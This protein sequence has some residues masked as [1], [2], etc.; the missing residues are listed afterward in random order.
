[1]LEFCVQ[2]Q[3]PPLTSTRES[4]MMLYLLPLCKWMEL[5]VL[6]VACTPQCSTVTWS[7]YTVAPARLMPSITRLLQSIVPPEIE[8]NWSELPLITGPLAV[9]VTLMVPFSSTAVFEAR[10]KGAALCVNVPF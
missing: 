4:R 1:M 8:T 3:R 10:V 9:D 2:M 7:R 5:L 6:R